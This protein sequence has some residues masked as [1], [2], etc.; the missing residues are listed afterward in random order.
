M[1]ERIPVLKTVGEAYRLIARERW[2]HL[3]AIWAPIVFLVAAEVCYHKIFNGGDTPAKIWDTLNSAPWYWLAGLAI[4]WLAG[5]KFLL[6]FSIS[7][8]RHLLLGERFDPFYFEKPFWRY[9]GFLLLTYLWLAIGTALAA[10]PFF[11]ITC[12]QVFAVWLGLHC[13][14]SAYLFGPALLVTVMAWFLIR[15][16]PFFTSLALGNGIDW[17]TSFHRMYFNELRYAAIWLLAMA[18]IFAV[19]FAIGQ[20]VHRLGF[21]VSTVPVALFESVVR[22]AALFIHVSLGASIGAI[23]Y[24]T[25]VTNPAE[26]TETQ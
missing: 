12:T 5:L 15:Q 11:P 17:K 2:L 8:R 20:I 10:L 16:V 3:K 18:P 24:R 22:Q 13:P 4:T 9:L 26:E 1:T 19:T 23:V 25:F 14:V 6:S 7:W 21:D